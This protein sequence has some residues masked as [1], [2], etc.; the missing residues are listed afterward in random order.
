MLSEIDAKITEWRS[1]AVEPVIALRRLIGIPKT[2]DDMAGEVGKAKGKVCF[3]KFR[4]QILLFISREDHIMRERQTQANAANSEESA[5][6]SQQVNTE[7]DRSQD[8][9]CGTDISGCRR[10]TAAPVA[11]KNIENK[12]APEPKP[13]VVHV[14]G[15]SSGFTLD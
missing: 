2:I 11:P 3:D 12:S 9:I 5:A 10:S 13:E 4:D 8:L 15:G 6:I 14:G 7:V 1:N